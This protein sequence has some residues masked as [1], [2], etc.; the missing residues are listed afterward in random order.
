[1]EWAVVSHCP[2][3]LGGAF[4]LP[5]ESFLP[6][7][8]ASDCLLSVTFLLVSAVEPALPVAVVLVAATPWL[9]AESLVAGFST[10]REAL[11]TA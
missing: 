11:R 4:P 9:A 10:R 8:D 5:V 7:L 3:G 2:P 6:S 1:M